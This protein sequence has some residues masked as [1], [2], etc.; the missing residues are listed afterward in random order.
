MQKNSLVSTK[1]GL[2]PACEIVSDV[3]IHECD[4]VIISSPLETPSIFSAMYKASV[5]F[6]TGKA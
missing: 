6:P 3:E 2:P 5:P 1:T 4:V